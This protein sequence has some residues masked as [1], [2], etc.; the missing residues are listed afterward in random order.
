MEWLVEDR[1][2]T[3]LRRVVAKKTVVKGRNPLI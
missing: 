2:T 3:V 1:D